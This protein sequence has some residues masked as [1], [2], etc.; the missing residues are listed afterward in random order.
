MPF[1]VGG[2]T[3]IAALAA[4]IIGHVD[5]IASL[6][7]ALLAFFLGYVFA[8]VWYA[9]FGGIGARASGTSSEVATSK[10]DGT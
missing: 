8:A 5:P 9:F 7:R 4:G 2:L 10:D 6:T 1:I 3:A